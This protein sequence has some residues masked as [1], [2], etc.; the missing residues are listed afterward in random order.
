MHFRYDTVYFNAYSFR[1]SNYMHLIYIYI[2][3]Y[4]E[5][6]QKDKSKKHRGFSTEEEGGKRKRNKISETSHISKSKCR[7]VQNMKLTLQKRKKKVCYIEI[8]CATIKG[9]PYKFR[10][11]LTF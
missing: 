9:G 11:H 6:H 7:E 5:S 10:L 1:F 3:I 4:N 2:Y 8:T